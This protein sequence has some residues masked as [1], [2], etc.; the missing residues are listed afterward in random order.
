MDKTKQKQD[1][2]LD[3]TF[4]STLQTL[5]K[6][7]A[8]AD[9]DSNLRELVS[10]VRR[11]A[12]PGTITFKIEVSPNSRG[13][14]E[15]LKLEDSISLKLPKADTGASIFYADDENRLVRNDPRQM[16]HPALVVVPGEPVAPIK[17]VNAS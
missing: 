15:I 7:V 14:V 9:L 13:N 8:I 11:T 1:N 12:R 17:Q 10:H 16:E 2:N 6:G 3:G 4:L 5:R